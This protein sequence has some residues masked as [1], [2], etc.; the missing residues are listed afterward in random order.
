MSFA[1][2]IAKYK[3]ATGAANLTTL[4]TR[5]A[6]LKMPASTTCDTQRDVSTLS[7]FTTLGEL[8]ATNYAR[9]TLAGE[10]VTQDNTNNRAE[11]S[12]T[13]PITWTALGGATNDTI[14]AILLFA[15]VTADSDSWPIAY[16]DNAG[17]GF[18]LTTN[19]S[20][21]SINVN[22]EGLLQFAD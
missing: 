8:V 10:A 17:S 11:F 3:F 6:L 4:D 1:Y 5:I 19:G 18:N 7:G 20:D 2:N 13:S 16:I 22:A 21:F 15:F 14:G 12:V 9:K